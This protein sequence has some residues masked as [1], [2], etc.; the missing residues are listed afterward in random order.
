MGIQ[1]AL[2]LWDRESAPDL[3]PVGPMYPIPGVFE[4]ISPALF[5]VGGNGWM[6]RIHPFPPKFSVE[7][8]MQ[9]ALALPNGGICDARTLGEF[10]SL[11]EQSG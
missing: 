8:V 4:T 2:A 11:A 1:F 6:L 7:I 3:F 10:A 9:Y 5:P